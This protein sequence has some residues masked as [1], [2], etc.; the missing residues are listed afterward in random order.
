M[1]IREHPIPGQDR[2]EHWE[3][4][5][6][7]RTNAVDYGEMNGSPPF[8]GYTSGHATFGC[9]VFEMIANVYQSYDGFNYTSPEWN[10]HSVDQF[11][12]TRAC[13]VREF[14]T[15]VEAMAESD[16]SRVYNG[17]NLFYFVSPAYF[18]QCRL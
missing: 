15:L 11:N 16:V 8:P 4:L 1:A 10:G 3:P 12:R 9:A 6:G 13:I 18:C 17:E 5:G 2:D 7:S 14:P